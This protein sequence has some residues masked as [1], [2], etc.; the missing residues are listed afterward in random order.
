MSNERKRLPRP[1]I[2]GNIF[3][4]RLTLLDRLVVDDDGDPVTTVDDLEVGGIDVDVD[5]DPEAPLPHVTAILSGNALPT[6]IFGGRPPDSRLDRIDW[7]DVDSLGLTV[8]LSVPGEG[9]DHLWVERWL[10]D[11]IIGRIPGGHHADE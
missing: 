2:D 11:R 10:R 3:D 4:A 8:T 1:S 7:E 9:L 6:R 5:L